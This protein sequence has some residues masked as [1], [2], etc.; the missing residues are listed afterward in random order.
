MTYA[1]MLGFSG[2]SARIHNYATAKVSG[3]WS[4]MVLYRAFISSIVLV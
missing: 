1:C 4:T 3:L 2:S